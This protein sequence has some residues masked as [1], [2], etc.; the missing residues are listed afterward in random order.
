MSMVL[1]I[2]FAL[3][4]AMSH[5]QAASVAVSRSD[6]RTPYPGPAEY[7]TGQ[8]HVLPLFDAKEPARTA[9]ASVTFDPGARTAWHSHPLGQTLIVT[10]GTG[11]VQRWGDAVQEIRTGDVVWIPPNQKHWHGAAPSASMT[12]TAIHEQ[13]DGKVVEWLEHVSDVQYRAAPSNEARPA[14]GHDFGSVAPALERYRD[15]VLQSDLWKRPGLTARDRSMVTIAALIARN[16][17]TD[18]REQFALALDNGVKPGEISEVITHLAF[19]AGWPNASSAV[20]VVRELFTTRNVSV[21]DLPPASPSLLPLNEAAEKERAAGVQANFGLVS[22]GVVQYTTD[23][24]FRDL[25][26]RLGLPPRDRSLVTVSALIAT[27]KVEQVPYHLNRAMDSGLTSSQ[28]SEVL[29]HLAFYAGWPSV[30]SA[31]PVVKDIFEKRA[32]TR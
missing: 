12:H 2:S 8:V 1:A 19:Y 16:Q 30:F 31:L 13:L 5:E 10:A 14:Q 25:W 15:E 28:T 17:Q 22:P 7:F 11:R 6:T 3:V 24:L 9:G 23:V 18:M 32:Q 20:Q 27:G 4:M 29:T 26:R 21:K